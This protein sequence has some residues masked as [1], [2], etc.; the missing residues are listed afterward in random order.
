MSVRSSLGGMRARWGVAAWATFAGLALLLLVP[1]S[2]SRA[3]SEKKAPAR[4]P[5]AAET[6]E[7]TDS[8]ASIAPQA[9]VREAARDAARA[10]DPL[11]ALPEGSPFEVLN[12]RGY[13][14]VGTSRSRVPGA[15]PARNPAGH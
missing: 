3:Q 5:G 7:S 9:W 13:N 10:A 11:V 8:L 2:N 1:E 12:G 15:E 6:C 14:Y 4:L